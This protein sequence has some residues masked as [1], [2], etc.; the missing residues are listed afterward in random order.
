VVTRLIQSTKFC[1]PGPVSTAMSDCLWTGKPSR[2]TC[3][4]PPR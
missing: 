1:M 3:N 4:Q 2:Y